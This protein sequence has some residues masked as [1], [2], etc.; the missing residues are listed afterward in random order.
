M[1]K[2]NYK[3]KIIPK[4]K[5]FPIT[6]KKRSLKFKT[7]KFFFQ[8]FDFLDLHFFFKK[9]SQIFKNLFLFFFRKLKNLEIKNSNQFFYTFG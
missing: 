7:I 2:N 9:R 4:L 5:K 8:K 1:K 6:K 3:L